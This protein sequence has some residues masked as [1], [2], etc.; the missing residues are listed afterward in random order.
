MTVL[1]CKITYLRPDGK[2]TSVTAYNKPIKGEKQQNILCDYLKYQSPNK[3]GVI[4]CVD[5]QKGVITIFPIT[6]FV[7]V[8]AIK[9]V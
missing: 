2:T 5:V 1:P 9:E 3:Y 8:E 7:S 4:Q 6:H